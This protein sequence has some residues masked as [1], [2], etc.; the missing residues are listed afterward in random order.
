[1]TRRDALLGVSVALVG[2]LLLGAAF[3]FLFQQSSAG[4]GVEGVIVSRRLEAAPETQ[5]T[6][7]SGSVRRRELPGVCQFVVRPADGSDT[8]L[9]TI[10]VD[11]TTYAA[12]RVGD[13]F[14]FV[15]PATAAK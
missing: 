11:P 13:R 14:Y 8:R 10:T 3:Y 4:G 15:R 6:V 9:Y 2:C 12:H 5:I 7:G 1:M